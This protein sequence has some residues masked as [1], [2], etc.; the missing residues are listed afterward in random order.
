MAK[1]PP[2]APS[3]EALVFDAAEFSGH[4]DVPDQFRWPEH[5]TPTPDAHE[6]LADVPSIDLDRLLSGDPDAMVS[7]A[8]ACSRYGLFQVVNHGVDAAL[9]AEARGCAEA[10]FAMPIA[11]KR[12]A[13]RRPGEICG[14]ASSFT[15][16]FAS[17]LPGRG[18]RPSRSASPP[19]RRPAARSCETTS[20][21]T[22]ATNSATLGTEVYLRYCEAMSRLSLGIMEAL[23]LSLGVGRAHFRDL[24]E[25]NESIVRLNYYPPCPRP[26]VTLGTGPHCDPTSLTVLHQEGVDGL[27]VFTDDDSRWRTV[28]PRPDAFVVN[29]GD[30]FMALSNGRYKSCMHR[31]VVNGEAARKS[32]VFFLCPSADK[33]VRPAAGLVDGDRPRLYPDFRWPQLLEFTQKHY[34]AD[35]ETLDAF[36]KWIRQGNDEVKNTKIRTTF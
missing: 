16:R 30:T 28:S 22:W 24:F 35:L 27:Q 19:R 29:I 36:S 6:E 33:V 11:E 2:P 26:E 12:R 15:E 14:Y 20:S 10:F 3:P 18:R 32:L 4:A 17:K 34:R 13:R 25:D 9:L 31:A 21:T 1:P 7:V 8:D 23:G 5:E